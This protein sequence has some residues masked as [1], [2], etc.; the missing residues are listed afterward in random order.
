MSPGPSEGS[1]AEG[2]SKER[3]CRGNQRCGQSATNGSALTA[4]IKNAHGQDENIGLKV[5]SVVIFHRTYHIYNKNQP[6]VGKHTTHGSY[7]YGIYK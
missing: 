6:K 2:G 3:R 7:G 4:N 1:L 5:S